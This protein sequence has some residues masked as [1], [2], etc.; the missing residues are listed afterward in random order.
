MPPTTSSFRVSGNF[1]AGSMSAACLALPSLVPIV[2]HS[3]ILH[4]HQKESLRRGVQPGAGTVAGGEDR[5]KVVNAE[6]AASNIDKRPNNITHHVAQE[7]ARF[8]I[9]NEKF[10]VSADNAT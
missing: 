7:G 1:R 5:S 10:A 4:L 6:R 3:S 8:D 9:V 2:R